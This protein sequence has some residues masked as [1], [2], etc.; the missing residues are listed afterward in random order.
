MVRAHL[1][2]LDAARGP[3][4]RRPGGAG[5]RPP[6]GLRPA[7]DRR[8]VGRASSTRRT[9]RTPGRRTSR[10]CA[11][12]RRIVIRPTWRRHRR[13]AGR[14]GPR[15][16]PGHGVRDRAPPDDAAVPRGARVAGG[17][18]AAGG[19]RRGRR[20]GARPR[21]RLRVRDPVDRG[22]QL[23]A[24]ARCSPWTWT[25]SPSRRATANARRN[26]L[27]RVIRAREGSAPSGEGPFDVVLANLIASLLITPRRRP[28]GG[29]AARR[30]AARVR[31][32]REPR[33]GRRRGVRG[34]RPGGRAPL[35][36][37]RLGGAGAPTAP[38]D[39]HLG[40]RCATISRP[41]RA[42]PRRAC[43]RTWTR[44]PTC[45]RSSR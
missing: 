24:P 39:G 40:D 2:I 1:P 4:R 20:P 31:D 9:G 10:C 43:R 32:L 12:G 3:R 35:G 23:G 29:P 36:R 22:G 25:R 17:P 19:R 15:A 18:R 21:R 11:I 16:R 7:A 28:G 44:C 41:A 33:G 38:P 45:P 5:P 30:H 8:P 37:G 6:P 27:A 26:R 42:N 13:A 34:A 14:R